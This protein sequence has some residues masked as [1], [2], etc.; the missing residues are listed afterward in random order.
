MNTPEPSKTELPQQEPESDSEEFPQSPVGRD[1]RRGPT[2]RD[3]ITVG[4]FAALYMVVY[5]VFS[6]LGFM[7]PM[8]LV[9]GLLVGLVIGGIPFM[10]FLTR[11]KTPGM[12]TLFAVLLGIVLLLT[13]HPPVATGWLLVLAVICEV[14]IGAGRYRS[15][16]AFIAAYTVFSLWVAGQFFPLF[17]DRAGFLGG[18]GMSQMSSEYL[19]TL[20]EVLSVRNLILF[21]MALIPFGLAGALLGLRLIDKH[22][23]RAGLS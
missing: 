19:E 4:I 11:V 10:L 20:D 17:Y 9:A 13:G 14:I 1:R 15:R 18:A 5:F 23:R 21:D 16:T 3:L 12:I 8:V 2:A 22:F 6:F 7:N